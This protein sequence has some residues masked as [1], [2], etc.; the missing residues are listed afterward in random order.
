[1]SDRIRTTPDV[2]WGFSGV[3]ATPT[4]LCLGCNKSRLGGG[5]KGSGIFKRCA[6]CLAAKAEAKPRA[7]G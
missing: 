6:S 5:S 4:F 2:R 1:M 3:G 7:A